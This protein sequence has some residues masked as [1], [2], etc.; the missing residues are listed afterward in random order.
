MEILLYPQGVRSG[1]QACIPPRECPCPISFS[2]D[3]LLHIAAIGDNIL[4][5]DFE[6][7]D[8][9]DTNATVGILA[10]AEGTRI[11]PQAWTDG[12]ASKIGVPIATNQV[13]RVSWDV[14]RTGLTTGHHQVRNSL[15]RRKPNQTGG[16]PLSH[17]TLT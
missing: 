4:D 12:T 1:I 7:I 16:P 9:D 5:L 10:Y 13:H 6:I 14:S 15:P 11:L 2:A 8:S 3:D 17:S